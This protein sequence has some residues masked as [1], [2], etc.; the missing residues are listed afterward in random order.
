LAKDAVGRFSLDWLWTGDD[1]GGQNALMMNPKAWR[2]MIKPQLKRLFDFGKSQNLWV[3]HHSCGSI[4]SIIDDLVEIGL[5]VLNPIQ[6]NCPGMNPYEL[7]KEYGDH[8]T[9][10]GGIDTQYLLPNGTA[11][12]VQSEVGRLVDVMSFGGGYILAASHTIPPETPLENIFAMYE[13]VGITRE[14][15][16]DK[17]GDVRNSLK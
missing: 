8:L 6:S 16:L 2:E 13:A 7:K 4:R 12:E 9:F 5:E 1:V 3:A 17:A 15:I 11:L 10:M 14:M